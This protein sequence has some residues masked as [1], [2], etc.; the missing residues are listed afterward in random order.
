MNQG[1]RTPVLGKQLRLLKW[2]K[3]VIVWLRLRFRAGRRNKA[4]ISFL[5]AGPLLVFLYH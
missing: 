5:R 2:L 4:N 1:W 3:H